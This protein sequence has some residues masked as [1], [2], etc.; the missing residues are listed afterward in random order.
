M[1]IFSSNLPSTKLAAEAQHGLISQV[2][3][4]VLFSSRPGSE[5]KANAPL[6]LK[7]AIESVPVDTTV[8]G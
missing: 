1:L 5:Q 7:A 8:A 6:T 4:D 2:L 3:K